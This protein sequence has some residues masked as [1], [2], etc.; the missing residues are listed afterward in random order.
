[1]EPLVTA[2]VERA[3]AA[4]ELRPDVGPTDLP[5]IEMMLAAMNDVPVDRDRVLGRIEGL[6]LD[7]LRT[8]RDEPTPLP[9]RPLKPAEFSR[10]MA[11]TKA[12]R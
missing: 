5:L 10:L 4:G 9:G 11:D 1:M 3:Q 6:I 2:L 8:R 7:G 12:R